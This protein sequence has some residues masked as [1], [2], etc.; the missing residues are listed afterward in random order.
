MISAANRPAR[1]PIHQRRMRLRPI[2][3]FQSDLENL[4]IE[5]RTIGSGGQV[6]W[7]GT[8]CA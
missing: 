5:Y 7:I 1:K 3:G 8:K 4:E 6:G 2:G